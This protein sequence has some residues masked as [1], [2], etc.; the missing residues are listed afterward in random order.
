MRS[1]QDAQHAYISTGLSEEML[2]AYINNN[3]RCYNESTEFADRMEAA[4]DPAFKVWLQSL[5]IPNPGVQFQTLVSCQHVLCL[6]LPQ[7]ALQDL[8]V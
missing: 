1:L 2:C 3:M 7:E 5:P 6:V 8:V 4:L